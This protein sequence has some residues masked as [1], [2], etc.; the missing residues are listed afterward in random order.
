MLIQLHLCTK[1]LTNIWIKKQ[2]CFNLID[3]H[4]MNCLD[5]IKPKTR[6]NKFIQKISFKD[7]T[8]S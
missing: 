2:I 7:Y 5:Q 1:L 3:K 4:E 8:I 6:Y